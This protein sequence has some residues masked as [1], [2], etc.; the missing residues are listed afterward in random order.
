[1]D[2]SASSAPIAGKSCISHEHYPN[3]RFFSLYL[4]VANR[5]GQSVCLRLYPCIKADP[6][7]VLA[8]GSQKS[9]K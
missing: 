6:V 8:D 4:A 3:V 7:A 2:L 9:K 5:A 1:M